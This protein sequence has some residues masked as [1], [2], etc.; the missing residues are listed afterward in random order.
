MNPVLYLENNVSQNSLNHL[1]RMYISKEISVN[2]TH[3][4]NSVLSVLIKHYKDKKIDYYSKIFV[5]RLILLGYILN[6]DEK[7]S[8]LCQEYYT[9]NKIFQ[10]YTNEYYYNNLVFSD[11]IDIYRDIIFTN[12]IK[13]YSNNIALDIKSIYSNSMDKENILYEPYVCN[14]EDYLINNNISEIELKN[15]FNEIL[16][17]TYMLNCIGFLHLNIYPKNI[18]IMSDRSIR[19][20]DFSN[21]IF[22]GSEYSKIQELMSDKRL[23]MNGVEILKTPKMF[24][25]YTTDCYYIIC[26]YYSCLKRQEFKLIIPL[27]QGLYE[28]DSSFN[29]KQI[30][31]LNDEEFFR[32][33]TTNFRRFNCK[34]A[35]QGSKDLNYS[36]SFE[37]TDLTD[38]FIK[39]FLEI[40]MKDK[41]ISVNDSI[42][43]KYPKIKVDNVFNFRNTFQLLNFTDEKIAFEGFENYFRTFD[44]FSFEKSEKIIAHSNFV[45]I[46]YQDVEEMFKLYLGRNMLLPETYREIS[47]NNLL[48]QNKSYDKF[49]ITMIK[50][51]ILKN[52]YENSYDDKNEDS[53]E[54]I[55]NTFLELLK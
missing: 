42:F 34:E 27:Y 7:K 22:L 47:I 51:E 55:K 17:K 25:N 52:I 37:C 41:L 44:N 49:I 21:S 5:Y 33:C 2:F 13:N 8:E 1:L 36:S 6:D 39:N 3:Q 12:I 19:L 53:L 46:F 38:H 45:P 10:F 4:G 28:V 29:I 50:Q 32:N 31:N 20:K 15:I 16:E 40:H 26:L 23:L 9:K 14:L 54:E 18:V 11:K 48:I 35:L 43:N 30:L 24:V